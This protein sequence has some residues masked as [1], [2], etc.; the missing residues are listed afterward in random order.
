MIIYPIILGCL[1]FFMSVKEIIL[2]FLL[3]KES[4]TKKVDI[5]KSNN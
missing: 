4:S 5:K 1:R 2:L 3:K